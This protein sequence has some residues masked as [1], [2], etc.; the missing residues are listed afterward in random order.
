MSIDVSATRGPLGLL[1]HFF[2]ASILP[3]NASVTCEKHHVSEIISLLPAS[4][5]NTLA[6]GVRYVQTWKSA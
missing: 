4:N 3:R 5:I 6:S 2:N 1:C